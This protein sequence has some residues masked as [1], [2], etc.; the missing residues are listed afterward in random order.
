MENLCP[1][2]AVRPDP[3]AC[4]D[5]LLHLFQTTD[6]GPNELRVGA[7]LAR[8][9]ALVAGEPN[10]MMCRRELASLTG[11]SEAAVQ[12]AL[13]ILSERSYIGRSQ[14]AKA[15]GQIAVTTVTD[16]LLQL[17]G[18]SGGIHA[19]ADIPSELLDLLVR[20]NVEV[21]N[22]ITAAWVAADMP[23]AAVASAFR[24]GAR[25]WAQVEFLMQSRIEAE[26]MRRLAE[27]EAQADAP[28]EDLVQLADG[29]VI[30]FDQASFHE[31]VPD[32]NTAMAGADLRFA[33]EVLR[34]V[35]KRSPTALSSAAAPKLAA[36]ALYSRQKG[37]VYRHNFQDAARIV[38]SVMAR[39]TWSAPRGIDQSWY[40][41]T[42]AAMK[43]AQGV[44]KSASLN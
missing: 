2:P 23:A 40:A 7:V 16:R 28:S 31:R 32:R 15:K 22:A 5:W 44:F 25:R 17:F 3:A 13:K 21:A 37:F 42:R 24:G 4:V 43:V 30:G 12:R 41:A 14:D 36:E 8:A 35:A 27:A 18:F 33:V 34:L 39:G 29:T 6:L 11:L 20:E 1:N 38:A 19:P 26:A 10:L 9:A